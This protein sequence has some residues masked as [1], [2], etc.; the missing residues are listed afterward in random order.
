N[1]FFSKE[2]VYDAALSRGLIFYLF[3]AVGS[4]FTAASFLKLGH[5]VYLGKLRDEHKNV[6]EASG[7]MLVPMMIIASVCILFGVYNVLPL[8]YLIQPVLQNRL[9]GLNFYGLPSNTIAVLFTIVILA[10]ALAN[11]IYGAMKTGK[12][13]KAVDHI[14]YAPVLKGI[15]DRAEKRY[16]DPYDIAMKG[17]DIFSRLLYFADRSIDWLYDVFTVKT[18]EIFSFIIRKAHSGNVSLYVVWALIGSFLVVFYIL[19]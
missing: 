7:V 19:R 3:A 9:G 18:A 14:H 8:K 2:L 16:F 10:G 13:V 5:A 17:A 4:F 1:G 6:K 12:G 15:Y 11:H